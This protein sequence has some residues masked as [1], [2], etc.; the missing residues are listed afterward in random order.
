MKLI[1]LPTTWFKHSK[2][3]FVVPPVSKLNV[4]ITKGFTNHK[5]KNV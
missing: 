4:S 3:E 5:L 2:V 1:T